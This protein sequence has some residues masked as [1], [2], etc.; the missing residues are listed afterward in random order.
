MK[1][2]LPRVAARS[3]D[4]PARRLPPL[5]L[6]VAVG[7]A[8]AAAVVL[9][10]VVAFSPFAAGPRAMLSG[11]ASTVP[12]A[13]PPYADPPPAGMGWIPGGEFSMGCEDPRG[14][15][16]GG[17]D[18]MRDARPIHRVQVS[19]FWMDRTEVTNAQFAAFVAATDYVT[20]AERAPKA[21]DFP[22]AP[23]ENLI[24]GSLVFTPPPGPVPLTNHYSW[25]NYVAGADW[26][27]PT[28]PT[29]TIAGNDDSPVVQVGHDDASAYAV[30]AGKRL[31][32][33]AE[34]EFA[35]RGGVAGG[36]YPWGREFRPAGKL[37][38]NTWQGQF[39]LQNTAADG[40]VG[41]APVGRFPA[42]AYGLHDM[43]GNVWEWCSDWYRPDA[44]A[45]AIGQTT[46]ADN[47]LGPADSFDPQEPD[48]KKRVL[49]GGSFL[50]SEQYCA[51][52]IVGTRGKAE[53]SSGCSHIG[54]R[55]V[56]AK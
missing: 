51:R 4:V 41:V 8:A 42:N 49:R 32:T 5:F 43:S 23:P 36:I 1:N 22:S 28:G 50:C 52:Y 7:T 44:Y 40:Y 46:P 39:P 20:V 35:A 21:E 17:P 16:F 47:P 38:A 34:W 11:F 55:C 27:H 56:K 48:Q 14:L 13:T 12:F 33:E 37:M 45:A 6:Q 25:W 19:G 26:R 24:P 29:S 54:F 18:P 2:T 3:R 9:A 53:P 10:C 15:P 30:W 31:P